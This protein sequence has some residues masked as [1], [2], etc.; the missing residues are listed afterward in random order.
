M[1]IVSVGPSELDL[2]MRR[3][4]QVPEPAVVAMVG[5]LR[6]KGQLSPLVAVRAGES[7]VLIDGFVRQAA[8]VRLGLSQ[9]VVEVVELSPV[10][11]KAQLYLR[12]RERGLLLVEECRL[13]AELH[14][15][16][17]LT[18]VEIGDLLER[19]KSWVS[20]RLALHRDLSPHLIEDLSLGLLGGGAIRRLALLPARNQEELVAVARRHRLGPADTA[21]LVELWRRA[22]DPEARTYLIDHPREALRQARGE[23]VE[24]RTP[25]LAGPARQLLESLCLLS[26]VSRRIQRVLEEGLFEVPHDAVC[27]IAE[28]A[29]RAGDQCRRTLEAVSR[30]TGSHG[31]DR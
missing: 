1:E 25:S 8:A 14:D 28:A 18:G 24:G 30:W 26:A 11:M 17:G 3:L 31:G 22:T 20:R 16:D 23:R 6:S 10:Q 15:S 9:V 29:A 19:H 12:H 2:S 5:S 4:R 27:H 7:L 21:A 13:V